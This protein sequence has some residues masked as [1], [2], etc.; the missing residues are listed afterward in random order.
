MSTVLHAS[1]NP[2]TIP[3]LSTERHAK[4]VSDE[5]ALRD[6]PQETADVAS[7]EVIRPDEFPLFSTISGVVNGGSVSDVTEDGVVVATTSTDVDDFLPS[8]DDVIEHLLRLDDDDPSTD[9]GSVT[10]HSEPLLPTNEPARSVGEPEVIRTESMVV[11]TSSSAMPTALSLQY[12]YPMVGGRT[13]SAA[14]G[15]TIRGQSRPVVE[16]VGNTTS[17]TPTGDVS[18][19]RLSAAPPGASDIPIVYL[20]TAPGNRAGSGAPQ[21]HSGAAPPSMGGAS[22]AV[23]TRAVVGPTAAAN[24]DT[25][26]VLRQVAQ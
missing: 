15:D 14:I 24:G 7:D 3:S 13:P 1:L 23:V 25:R 26:P 8:C 5:S 10:S 17:T 12:Q 19:I 11:S 2:A 16:S 6:H 20:L 22:F 4:S 9:E 21:P 18:G